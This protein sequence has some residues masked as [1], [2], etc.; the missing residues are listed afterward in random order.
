MGEEAGKMVW[1]DMVD[2]L[3]AKPRQLYS[4]MEAI[5]DWGVKGEKISGL[6]CLWILLPWVLVA[7]S[8]KCVE[9]VS[10]DLK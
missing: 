8:L 4:V 1:R 5:K 6:A 7:S 2:C 10:L 9:S 3:G